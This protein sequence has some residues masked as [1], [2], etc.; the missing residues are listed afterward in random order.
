[1]SS[2]QQDA[3]GVQ[4]YHVQI[5]NVYKFRNS[6]CQELTELA[7]AYSEPTLS[8]SE[9]RTFD[10]PHLEFCDS[11]DVLPTWIMFQMP[12]TRRNG[13]LWSC[14][15]CRKSKLRCDHA[16]PVCGRCI[17]RDRQHLCVYHPSPLTREVI[18]GK[19]MRDPS[20]KEPTQ[21]SISS[22]DWSQRKVT[23]SAPG[24]L[25]H[26]SY[27]D[28]FRDSDSG[29][30]LEGI[31]P[32]PSGFS[33]D[34]ERIQRGARALVPL[35][36]LFLYREMLT[37]R[38]KIWKG[39]TLA[40]PITLLILSHTEEMWDSV[41]RDETDTTKQ[42]LLLSRRLFE[43]QTQPIDL[44]SDTTCAEF[45][46]SIAGRWETIGLLFTL[47]GAASNA[48]LRDPG[49][50]YD[51]LGDAESIK[52]AAVAAGDLCLQFCQSAG[53][54]NDIVCSLLLHHTS[55]LT[56]VYGDGGKSS[57]IE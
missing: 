47:V 51:E 19:R 6:G 55:L 57:T 45:A 50:K 30:E 27:S 7:L 3:V 33:M 20:P 5:I 14:E 36:H 24:F 9:L 38:N 16:T 52:V 41:Q 31:S 1:M 28:A 13:Q 8:N 40:W 22:D 43:K 35:K 4:T 21:P 37:A 26:T 25:G 53:I 54:I 12:T 34:I 11:L 42:T 18:R 10:S 56:I 15:P 2:I 49:E 32:S 29:L 46:S 17:R 48:V 44:H 23:T 39:W